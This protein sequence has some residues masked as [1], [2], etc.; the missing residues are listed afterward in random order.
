MPPV[1]E[2]HF[3]NG[4]ELDTIARLQMDRRVFPG[5][6]HRQGR[7]PDD[8]P[9]ARTIQRID[10]A[11]KTRNANTSRHYRRRLFL[12]SDL[13]SRIRTPQVRKAGKKTY[14]IYPIRHS[15]MQIDHGSSRQSLFLC[16][17][18]QVGC[19]LTFIA[20]RDS[21][22]MP[23]YHP[24]VLTRNHHPGCLL[25]GPHQPSL[26][27]IIYDSVD[28]IPQHNARIIVNR[29]RTIRH[30]NIPDP[31]EPMRLEPVMQG[32]SPPVKLFINAITKIDRNS[33]I[34]Q[35]KYGVRDRQQT[36]NY[37]FLQDDDR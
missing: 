13:Q 21:K 19:I 24:P 34:T 18:F 3:R 35:G 10:P 28:P 15:A 17:P 23:L 2:L 9:S 37:H 29:N 22:K 4:I 32:N 31:R 8:L 12:P 33:R 36:T 20:D 16:H 14:H 26:H 1:P 11:L 7:S 27:S 5:I 30:Y 25:P 6:E